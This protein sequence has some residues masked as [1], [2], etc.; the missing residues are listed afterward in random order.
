M[1]MEAKEPILTLLAVGKE[2]SPK[3]FAS[4]LVVANVGPNDPASAIP[5]S[6]APDLLR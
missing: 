3:E 6:I 4:L 2:L 1:E 5:P